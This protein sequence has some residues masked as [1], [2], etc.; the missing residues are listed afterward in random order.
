VP[1]DV[2]AIVVSYADAIAAAATARTLLEQ[3]APPLEVLVVDNGSD[4]HE[5]AVAW[6][7]GVRVLSPAG[8]AG[9]VRACNRAAS[10]ARGRWLLF[11]N[12]DAPA[13]R[14][15]LARLRAAAEE[16]DVAV[17]G[18][19]VLLPGG[20]RVN[21]GDNPVHLS[22]LCWSGRYGEPRERGLARDV[23][24][25]SGAALMVRADVFAAL[26][27]F[28]PGYFM[29]HDDVDICWRARLA[30]WRVRYVP[31]ATVVHDYAFEKGDGPLQ[32]RGRHAAAAR[33]AAAGDGAGGA[34]AGAARR[35]GAREAARVVGAA[36]GAAGAAALAPARAGAAARAGRRAGRADDGADGLAAARRPG[37]ACC[38]SAAGR[39]SR[40]RAQRAATRSTIS[41]TSSPGRLVRRARTNGAA[42]RSP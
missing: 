18:A 19:Q 21:A 9:Y 39:L 14:D 41:V 38:R 29:Y 25:V 7:D 8:N 32:L 15:C 3:S 34:R 10:E 33:A 11:L 1:A 28:E 37:G 13:E 17:V 16:P 23:L 22:G 30:G 4:L 40:S 12:P 36:A 20:E 42:T 2:S 26:G 5:G 35:L 27:G 6:P 24:A 31:E